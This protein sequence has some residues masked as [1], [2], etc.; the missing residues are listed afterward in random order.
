[1]SV[2]RTFWGL[3]I[4]L[5]LSLLAGRFVSPAIFD[6]SYPGEVYIFT[7]MIVFVAALLVVGWVWAYFSL[8]GIRVRRDARVLRQQ[9]GQVFEER[10]KINNTTPIG[11][12]WLELRDES[13]LPGNYGSRVFSMIG[14]RQQRT[15][16]AYTLL[17]RRGAYRLGPTLI[18][19]GDPFGLF[20]RSARIDGGQELLV[21]PYICDLKTFPSP[22]GEFPGGKAI[23]RKA[24]EVTPQAAGVRE[25][26]PGD[27]LRVIHWPTSAR[28]DKLMVK[29]FEQDP[30]SEVWIFLDGDRNFRVQ[31]RE[32]MELPERVDQLWLLR[33]QST[34]ASLP[35]DTYE[36]GVSAAGSVASY[37][38]R[39]NRAV[40]I[41]CGGDST[42]VILPERGER[43]L[44]KILENLAFQSGDSRMPLEGLV[45]AE[46]K[47]IPRASTVVLITASIDPS[48]LASV[49]NLLMRNLKPVIVYLDTHSFGSLWSGDEFLLKLRQRPIP[50]LVVKN[51]VPL[52]DS[53]ERPL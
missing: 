7:R 48:V 32:P 2:R 5:A 23:L 18:G 13:G 11:R 19:S 27:S 20:K 12:L 30:Q 44:N 14:A 40:G 21:L 36:Y 45:E 6:P 31:K 26:L 38:L 28:K 41:V 22:T 39:H 51:G 3:L 35:A 43:Q 49:D 50:I 53:L 29:E 47:Q 8:T 52:S 1:M 17:K 10:F 33:K 37:F 24:N 42:T 16:V 34:A 15:Y 9:V 46:N 4:L 25:Y